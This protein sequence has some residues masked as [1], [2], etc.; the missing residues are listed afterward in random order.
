MGSI[1]R[2]MFHMSRKSLTHCWGCWMS[3]DLLA[4][5]PP[6]RMVQTCIDPNHQVIFTNSPPGGLVYNN[7]HIPPPPPPDG[8]S[9]LEREWPE[10]YQPQPATYWEKGTHSP[11]G[12]WSAVAVAFLKV[13]NNHRW[14]SYLP[15][16]VR[17]CLHFISNSPYRSP[18]PHNHLALLSL[19]YY[20]LTLTSFLYL[21][22]PE[23]TSLKL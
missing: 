15:P 8:T 23:I 22:F 21:H 7:T 4:P 11:S 17:A 18:L 20:P 19:G 6:P 1:F 14:F 10:L 2:R 16:A 5:S 3:V 13:R 12:S 9:Q